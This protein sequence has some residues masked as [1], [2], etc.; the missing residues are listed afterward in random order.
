MLDT[1]YLDACKAGAFPP[2]IAPAL[3]TIDRS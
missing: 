2:Y 3:G 1:V